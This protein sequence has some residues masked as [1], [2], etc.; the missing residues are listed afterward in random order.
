MKGIPMKKEK[1][2]EASSKQFHKIYGDQQR[3][4]NVI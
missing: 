1:N 2:C 3:L 4:N